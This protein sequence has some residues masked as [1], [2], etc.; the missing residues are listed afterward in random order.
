[1]AAARCHEAD[2][3]HGSLGNLTL[4]S[5]VKMLSIRKLV[6]KPEGRRTRDRQVYRPDSRGSRRGDS[7][8]EAV[9]YRAWWCGAVLVGLLEV[10]RDWADVEQSE[11]RI[12]DFNEEALIFDGRV[13]NPTAHPNTGLPRAAEDLCRQ[14]LSGSWRI[15]DPQPWRKPIVLGGCQRARHAGVAR[16]N[17]TPWR[18]RVNLRLHAGHEGL[19]SVLRVVEGLAHVPAQSVVDGEVGPGLVSVLPIKSE[20]FGAGIQQLVAGL[21]EQIGRTQQIIGEVITGLSSVEQKPSVGGISVAL[22]NLDV[23]DVAAE[24][25]RVPS[26]DLRKII[27]DLIGVVVLAGGAIGKAEVETQLIQT[28]GRNAFGSRIDRIDSQPALDI[29]KICYFAQPTNGFVFQEREAGIVQMQLVDSSG[30]DDA[31][32][33]QSDQLATRICNRGKAGNVGGKRRIGIQV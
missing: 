19:D 14:S 24:L 16:E 3:K 30:V 28:D 6:V 29:S 13:V 10:N 26:C 4:N 17:E 11:R 9:S 18:I 15:G 21:I 2:R 33:A 8:G 22:V 7:E 5:K 23:A 1:M 32:V 25:Q 12:A 31:G 27:G 20:V